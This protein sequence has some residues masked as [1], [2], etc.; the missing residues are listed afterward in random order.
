MNFNSIP[1]ALYLLLRHSSLSWY[2]HSYWYGVS[3]TSSSNVAP[4]WTSLLE[5]L[6]LS[7]YEIGQFFLI[8]THRNDIGWCTRKTSTVSE[9]GLCLSISWLLFILYIRSHIRCWC[10][11]HRNVALLAQCPLIT[12]SPVALHYKIPIPT[13]I[14]HSA[15]KGTRFSIAYCTTR[16]MLWT[17]ASGKYSGILSSFSMILSVLSLIYNE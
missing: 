2:L 6:S 17:P 11:M 8:G 3:I 16:L 10:E 12:V 14:V 4:V 7:R 9:Q 15:K 5:Q 1:E 13:L